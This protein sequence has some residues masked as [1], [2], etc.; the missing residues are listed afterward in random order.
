M[1]MKKKMIETNNFDKMQS[2]IQLITIKSENTL[3]F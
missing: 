3:I 2:Q 1:K